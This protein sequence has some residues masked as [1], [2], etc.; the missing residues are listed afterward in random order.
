MLSAPA[1]ARDKMYVYIDEAGN[2][3]FGEHGTQ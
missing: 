1:P 3:D 2:L